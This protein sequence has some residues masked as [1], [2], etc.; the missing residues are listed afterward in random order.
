MSRRDKYKSIFSSYSGRRDSTRM[1]H[2]K[3]VQKLGC[4]IGRQYEHGYLRG[5]DKH[6]DDKRDGARFGGGGLHC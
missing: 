2:E 5:F 4:K 3:Q 6:D 1:D